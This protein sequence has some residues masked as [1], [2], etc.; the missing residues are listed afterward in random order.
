MSLPQLSWCEAAFTLHAATAEPKVSADDR[1]GY[2]Q[3]L[4]CLAPEEL[5]AH[6]CVGHRT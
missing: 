4:Y 6:V 2:T 3:C 1:L 5:R